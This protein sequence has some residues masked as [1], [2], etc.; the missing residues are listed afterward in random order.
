[1]ADVNDPNRPDITFWKPLQPNLDPPLWSDGSAFQYPVDRAP[2]ADEYANLPFTL[3]AYTQIVSTHRAIVPETTIPEPESPKVW[4]KSDVIDLKTAIETDQYEM[5]WAIAKADANFWHENEVN[6][7]RR[8]SAYPNTTEDQDDV[9]SKAPWAF[10]YCLGRATKGLRWL[11]ESELNEG[12]PNGWQS[13]TGQKLADPDQTHRFWFWTR[14]FDS[15]IWAGSTIGPIGVDGTILEPFGGTT[16]TEDDWIGT[17]QTDSDMTENFWHLI[18]FVQDIEP[19]IEQLSINKHPIKGTF[20][21]E[22]YEDHSWGACV[23]TC[24]EPYYV[25]GTWYYDWTYSY[26]SYF[27]HGC[28]GYTEHLSESDSGTHPLGQPL[29]GPRGCRFCDGTEAGDAEPNSW[30]ETFFNAAWEW[31]IEWGTNFFHTWEYYIDAI[32]GV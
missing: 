25:D 15:G 21:E 29:G 20:Y 2:D 32:L 9:Y 4:K 19:N 26:N 23:H 12:A 24:G 10:N 8:A 5:E 17:P 6:D 7:L 16:G 28:N 14:Y 22:A 1:M 3:E 30:D 11:K 31:N 27:T 18:Q 13:L